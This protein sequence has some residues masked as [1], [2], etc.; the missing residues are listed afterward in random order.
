M[1]GD[2]VELLKAQQNQGAD[3]LRI[4]GLKALV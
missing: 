1:V 3:K 2:S 4:Q